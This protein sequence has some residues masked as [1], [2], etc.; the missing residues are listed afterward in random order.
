MGGLQTRQGNDRSKTSAGTR[1][2][3]KS[4][5]EEP[6]RYPTDICVEKDPGFQGYAPEGVTPW[7]P[8][9]K[10]KGKALPPEHQTQNRLIARIRM[11]IE[12]SIAG[13]QRGRMVKELFRNTQE[14][15]DDLVM[16]IA[17]ALH[18]F[19]VACRQA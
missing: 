18:N 17:C 6:P 12:P 7:Q 19:R 13:M 15:Y 5:E 10:P 16:E 4:A 8:Q 9:K 14:K 3:T 2:D 11:V 1:H